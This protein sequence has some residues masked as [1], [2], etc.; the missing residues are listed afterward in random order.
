M[1][2]IHP[3]PRGGWRSWL[4]RVVDIDEVHRF[5]SYTAH[6]EPLAFPLLWFM[7]SWH[8]HQTTRFSIVVVHAPYLKREAPSGS[9][10]LGF[11]ASQQYMGL[12]DS[13][14]APRQSTRDV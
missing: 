7:G 6:H 8:G 14:G 4:A 9:G 10:Q 5:E 13:K 2:Q 11:M 12:L 1:V 3:R